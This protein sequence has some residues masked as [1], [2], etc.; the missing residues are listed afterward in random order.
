M[1]YLLDHFDW[2]T[3]ERYFKSWE[4]LDKWLAG[5]AE[6]CGAKS[7]LSLH[8]AI[9]YMEKAGMLVQTEVGEQGIHIALQA[10]TKVDELEQYLRE[11]RAMR[12]ERAG[13]E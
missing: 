3:G 7:H 2:N 10:P 5:L 11:I 4:S 9:Y 6:K 12:A 8:R 1:L 13:A